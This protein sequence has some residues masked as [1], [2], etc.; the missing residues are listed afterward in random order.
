MNFKKKW[1]INHVSKTKFFGL[2]NRN[3][4]TII[5]LKLTN[6][7]SITTFLKNSSCPLVQCRQ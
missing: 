6:T 4:N 2:D 5:T 7:P 1:N 3:F